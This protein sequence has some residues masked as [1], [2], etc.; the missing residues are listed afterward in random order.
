MKLNKTGE[1][2][3]ILREQKGMTQD[4]LAKKLF[5]D[6]RKIYEKKNNMY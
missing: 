6:R 2:L 1:L 3:K 5:V 4:E